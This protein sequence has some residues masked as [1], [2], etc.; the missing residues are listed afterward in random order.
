[1]AINLLGVLADR[2]RG[3]ND[4]ITA[5]RRLQA[6]Y[7]HRASVDMLTGL[8]NRR[9]MDEMLPR[10]IGRSQ[11]NE[12]ALSL[13]MVD[14]DGFKMYNDCFGHQAGDFVLFALSR[15]MRQRLRPPDMTVRYGGDE[16]ALILPKTSKDEAYIVGERLRKAVAAIPLILS[17]QTPLPSAT[18]SLGIAELEKGQALEALVEEADR[19]L[20]RAKEEGCN[21]TCC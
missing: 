9:W 6:E 8:Y 17:D 7:R 14:V 16:F 15:I 5:S 10:Q 13:I 11:R 12:E 1:L 2:L 18:I 19:A 3:N 4:V 20:Y 21:R